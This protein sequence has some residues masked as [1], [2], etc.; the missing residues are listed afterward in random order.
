MSL[1]Q[2]TISHIFSNNRKDGS[3]EVNTLPK[4]YLLDGPLGAHVLLPLV[5]IPDCVDISE[6][7]CMHISPEA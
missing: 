3:W 4:V 2:F 7:S 1:F 5:L 6:R